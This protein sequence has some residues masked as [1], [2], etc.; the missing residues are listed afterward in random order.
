MLNA[1]K[2]NFLENHEFEQFV[3]AAILINE[4]T[5]YGL[6]S[7]LSA[8]CFTKPI[9][10]K[11]YDAIRDLADAG[12][13]LEYSIVQSRVTDDDISPG[14]YVGVL[15]TIADKHDGPIPALDFAQELRD[16]SMRRQVIKDAEAAI[17]ECYDLGKSAVTIAQ[18]T[19]ARLSILTREAAVDEEVSMH[20]AIQRVIDHA[21][22]LSEDKGFGHYCG[23]AKLHQLTGLFLPGDLIFF[24][25]PPAG[26]KTS[27]ATQVA[28]SIS[29]SS[30]SFFIQ[31]E[32]SL[33][34]VSVRV[35]AAH[36][37]VSAQDILEKNLTQAQIEQLISV[38]NVFQG[39]NLTILARRGMFMNDIRSR[40][41][42]YKRARGLGMVVIDHIGLIRHKGR[43][44]SDLARISQ[45]SQELKELAGELD[46]PVL[47]LAHFTKAS[48]E[49][50]NYRPR[51]QDFYG[52]GIE[53]DADTAIGI[54]DQAKLLE[55]RKPRDTT[56]KAFEKWWSE[57]SQAK[58]FVE[59]YSLKRR[60]GESNKMVKLKWDP[61]FTIFS[62]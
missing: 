31:Q 11:F 7:T 30:P 16:L 51:M 22:D 9:H 53:K 42:A 50:D 5:Y 58:G 6:Q 4:D 2:T 45:V 34:S 1:D 10:R 40:A 15:L 32:M 35:I 36:A 33:L 54:V 29:R 43:F 24:G 60:M 12:K 55:M 48:F 19:E 46:V 20:D 52:G 39:H 37:G 62:D 44:H 23:L 41:I 56:S 61:E 21:G 28:L 25:G 26:G 47:V 8:D 18:D 49:R 14:S 38:R 57:Y 13:P 3:L 17:K 59:L 27:L